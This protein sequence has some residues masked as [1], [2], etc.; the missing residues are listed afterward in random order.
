MFPLSPQYRGYFLT[1]LAAAAVSVFFIIYKK[2]L[3]TTTP[4]V[5]TLAMYV[6]GFVILFLGNRLKKEKIQLNKTT[7]WGGVIF[8]LLSVLGHIAI[9]KSLEGVG[10]S[11]TTVIL[12]TQIILVMFLGWL[13]LKEQLNRFLLPGAIVA[14]AG[15]IWMNYNG[16]QKNFAELPFYLWGF[17]AALC[18][19][20]SQVMVKAIIHKINPI[21][22]NLLRSFFGM[23]ALSS[24]PGVFSA[25]L[26]LT[27]IEWTLAGGAALFGPTLARI[28]QMYALRYIPVS[29]AILFSMLTPVFTLLM[30][31]FLLKIFP[32]S[33]QL[34]GAGIILAGVMIPIVHL[35]KS[36]KTTL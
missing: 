4:D 21:I 14:I 12:R 36:K 29:Q 3:E 11:I 18:F 25:L 15:F 23:L 28:L 32:S 22:M 13:I 27:M 35:T 31:W 33:Q 7:F 2:G 1:T 26:E 6:V 5:F 20:V 30:S 9:G 8:A 34:L 10:P 17:C 16:E 24:F 19:G